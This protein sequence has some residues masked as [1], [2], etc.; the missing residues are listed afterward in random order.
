ME[1]LPAG[2]GGRSLKLPL[3]PLQRRPQAPSCSCFLWVHWPFLSG[4]LWMGKEMFLLGSPICQSLC[5]FV[6][7]WLFC[8][9]HREASGIG[10]PFTCD[11]EGSACGWEDVSPT[12]FQWSPAQ[13]SISTGGAEPPFDHTLGTDLGNWF[14]WGGGQWLEIHCKALY[15]CLVLRGK[16]SWP[17]V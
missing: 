16:P 14:C 10:R 8:P 7:W 5:G 15:V 6:D 4:V 13:A 3:K 2:P 11:F 17:G 12:A 9:G 1:S